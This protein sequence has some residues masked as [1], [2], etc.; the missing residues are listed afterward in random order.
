MVSEIGY[1]FD[2]A[3]TAPITDFSIG[4]TTR[5]G[6]YHEDPITIYLYGSNVGGDNLSNWTLITTLNN[7]TDA[8]PTTASTDYKSRR[9]LSSD[10]FLLFA[11]CL[12][13]KYA[14]WW[15]QIPGKWK[16]WFIEFSR[17][18]FVGKI[19]NRKNDEKNIYFYL[20]WVIYVQP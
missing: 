12:S 7:T 15:N 1:Y 2:I 3:L 17:I 16:R 19:K 14:K 11:V 6:D 13:G 4:Y 8:L 9:F 5:S 20:V 10:F 18:P